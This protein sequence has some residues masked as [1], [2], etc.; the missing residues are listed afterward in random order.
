[1][2]GARNPSK[3]LHHVPDARGMSKD[4]QHV[5]QHGSSSPRGLSEEDRV[6]RIKCVDVAKPAVT[7]DDLSA[8]Y[9][10][11]GLWKTTCQA[12]RVSLEMPVDVGMSLDVPRNASKGQLAWYVLTYPLCAAMYITMPD[13][14]RS[15][16]PSLHRA[17][18]EFFPFVDVDRLLRY[19]PRRVDGG[20]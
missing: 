7:I 10:T 15:S 16:S 14:R 6:S 20:H 18:L 11:S 2:L 12:M 17:F 4:L 9:R 5:P 8:W 19:L 13:V 3:E 1:M